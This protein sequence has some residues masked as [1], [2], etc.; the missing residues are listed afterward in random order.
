ML[1]LLVD[2]VH[3]AR[4]AH[5]GMLETLG[6]EVIEA[7]DGRGAIQTAAASGPDTILM[8]FTLPDIDGLLAVAAMR[9]IS[10]LRHVPIVA[11]AASPKD[12]LHAQAL[13]AGCNAYL[14]K[15]FTMESL[16]NVLHRLSKA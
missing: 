11:T 16:A 3:D 15:P 10:H 7:S 14:E 13:A 5:R 4:K 6:H 8:E 12:L 9:A 1:I 2:D